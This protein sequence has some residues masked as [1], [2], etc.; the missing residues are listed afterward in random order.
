[1]RRS[2]KVGL[3]LAGVVA[4]TALALGLA[5]AQTGSVTVPRGPYV[6]FCPSPEQVA[7]HAEK[8]GFD[9]KP[10]VSCTADGEVESTAAE[11][12]APPAAVPDAVARAREKSELSRLRRAPDTDGNPA[13]IESVTPE[14]DEVVIIIQTS[15]PERFRGMTPAEF[16]DKAYP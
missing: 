3:G 9:Y 16:A 2:R 1:M 14:G 8:Y 15:E 4:A 7:A 11:G 10:T 12:Q 13:T 5:S 6:D